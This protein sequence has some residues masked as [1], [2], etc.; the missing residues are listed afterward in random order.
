MEIKKDAKASFFIGEAER[1]LFSAEYD[2][3]YAWPYR[4]G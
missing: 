2:R 4:R 1:V 3:E